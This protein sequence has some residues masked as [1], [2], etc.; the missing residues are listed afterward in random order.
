MVPHGDP[1]PNGV[2]G[3]HFKVNLLGEVQVRLHQDHLPE[4]GVHGHISGPHVPLCC[5]L[6]LLDSALILRGLLEAE[7]AHSPAAEAHEV[8]HVDPE[9]H[10]VVGPQV[11]VKVL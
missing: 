6:R 3:H 11:G 1:Q 2:G 9:P 5:G 10:G 4:H 8:P 7:E